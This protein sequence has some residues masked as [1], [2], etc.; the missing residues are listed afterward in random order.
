MKRD[1]CQIKK[2]LATG[3]V[4]ALLATQCFAYQPEKNYWD[5]RRANRSSGRTP[6]SGQNR[7]VRAEPSRFDSAWADRFPPLQ[8]FKPSLSPFLEKTVPSKFL[9]DHRPLLSALSPAYGTIRKIT[10]AGTGPTRPVVVHIQD[11]HHNAEAQG[12]IRAAV[13]DLLASGHVAVVALE[14]ATEPIDL[15]AFVDF[16]HRLPVKQA[17]DW[18]LKENKISGP[19]HAALTHHGKLPRI[20]GVDDPEHYAANVRAVRD[21]VQQAQAVR[22]AIETARQKVEHAKPAVYSPGLAALDKT[23]NDFRAE[24]TALGSYV[25]TLRSTTGKDSS[26]PAVDLFLSALKIE[27]VLDFQQV[28]REREQLIVKLTQ[29]LTKTEIETLLVETAAY[30]GGARLFGAFYHD[31]IALCHQKGVALS[32]FPAMMEYIRYALLADA[33]QSDHL[34]AEIGLLEK[35][36]YNAVVR[37]PQE[38]ELVDRSRRLWLASRLVNFAL[39]PE[40]WD[41]WSAQGNRENVDLASFESFY[42]EAQARDTAMANN[43]LN[44]LSSDGA[45]VLVTGGFHAEGVARLLEQR[46]VSVISFVPKLTKVDLA[47]G[48]AYLSVF[49]QEKTP[50]EKLFQGEKLFLSTKPIAQ[51]VRRIQLPVVVTLLGL[52][53]VAQ[54]DPQLTYALLGGLGQI[55]DVVAGAG[56]AQALVVVGAGALMVRVFNKRGEVQVDSSPERPGFLTT[57]KIKFW[58][59]VREQVFY[60]FPVVVLVPSLLTLLVTTTF[61]GGVGMALTTFLVVGGV[62][63]FGVVVILLGLEH[64]RYTQE[65]QVLLVVPALKIGILTLAGFLV[66]MV[67]LSP[68]AMG[69]VSSMDQFF[70]WI[71]AGE[72]KAFFL[73]TLA[74][75]LLGVW[76]HFVHN[77]KTFG[78]FLKWLGDPNFNGLLPLSGNSS[79]GK[80]NPAPA[81]SKVRLT[82]PA[83]ADVGQI[84]DSWYN[85]MMA[86]LR[87]RSVTD[88][89]IKNVVSDLRLLNPKFCS[90]NMSLLDDIPRLKAH[91]SLVK[92]IVNAAVFNPLGY[93]SLGFDGKRGVALDPQSWKGFSYL[94]EEI[95]M[96]K[97]G[98]ESLH[99][100]L[101][102]D[103]G[104]GVLSIVDVNKIG[105]AILAP[106]ARKK[107]ADLNPAEKASV[108]EWARNVGDAVN[109]QNEEIVKQLLKD[110]AFARRVSGNGRYNPSPLTSQISSSIVKD[111]PRGP[112]REFDAGAPLFVNARLSG[113]IGA[114]KFLITINQP[115]LGIVFLKSEIRKQLAAAGQNNSSP[116][117]ALREVTKGII[118]QYQPVQL[119]E[120]EKKDR[121]AIQTAISLLETIQARLFLTYDERFLAV[122]GR[123]PKYHEF[124]NKEIR[125]PSLSLSLIPRHLEIKSDNETSPGPIQAATPNEGVLGPAEALATE[126]PEEEA[127]PNKGDRTGI[128]QME[129]AFRFAPQ[130]DS[131]DGLELAIRSMRYF[132]D[133]EEAV[134]EVEIQSLQEQLWGKIKEAQ[135]PVA[136]LLSCAEALNLGPNETAFIRAYGDIQKKGQMPSYEEITDASTL[137]EE[138]VLQAHD[139]LVKKLGDL[140]LLPVVYEEGEILEDEGNVGG[141]Y[142]IW[143]EFQL[144]IHK[145]HGQKL[146]TDNSAQKAIANVFSILSQRAR[147]A[148]TH[149]ERLAIKKSRG[150]L[151]PKGVH[152]FRTYGQDVF[153]KVVGKTVVILWVGPTDQS[154]GTSSFKANKPVTELIGN[155]AD[156]LHRQSADYVFLNKNL[157]QLDTPVLFSV[158]EERAGNGKATSLWLLNGAELLGGWIGGPEWARLWGQFYAT[159]APAIE[160]TIGVLGVLVNFA[161]YPIVGGNGTLVFGV[162]SGALFFLSHFVPPFLKPT[163]QV[164]VSKL[165]AFSMAVI[166]GTLVALT[167]GLFLDVGQGP[168]FQRFLEAAGLV[169]GWFFALRLHVWFDAGRRGAHMDWWPI[170]AVLWGVGFALLF[171]FDVLPKESFLGVFP[172]LGTFRVGERKTEEDGAFGRNGQIGRNLSF[173]RYTKGVKRV[174]YL[175][176]GFDLNNVLTTFLG[177]TDIVMVGRGYKKFSAEDV[178]KAM[179]SSTPR[180]MK[181]QLYVDEYKKMVQESGFV[182]SVV[183]EEGPQPYLI[184]IE[185]TELG[186]D[187]ETVV[188]DESGE[189]LS[190]I[191]PSLYG[192]PAKQVHVE[193][194]NNTFRNGQPIVLNVGANTFDGIYAKAIHD[195]AIFLPNIFKALAGR[196]SPESKLVMNTKSGSLVPTVPGFRLESLHSAGDLGQEYGNFFT[197][198]ALSEENPGGKSIFQELPEIRQIPSPQESVGSIEEELARYE[199]LVGEDRFV[200]SHKRASPQFF[201]IWGLPEQFLENLKVESLRR[202]GKEIEIPVGPYGTLEFFSCREN[203]RIVSIEADLR[204]G[205]PHPAGEAPYNA[206]SVLMAVLLKKIAGPHIPIRGALSM[207]NATAFYNLVLRA[208]QQNKPITF[209]LLRRVPAF[210]IPEC[211]FTIEVTDMGVV[212]YT[213]EWTGQPGAPS[214]IARDDQ[215]QLNNGYLDTF[216]HSFERSSFLKDFGASL[217][218]RGLRGVGGPN[219][220]LYLFSGRAG[221]GLFGAA[222]EGV[223]LAWSALLFDPVL[224]LSVVLP[225]FSLIHVW[226]QARQN[227]DLG[228]GKM[229]GMFLWHWVLAVPYG[230]IGT[231]A[232][233]QLAGGERAA[234]VLAIGWHLLSDAYFMARDLISAR[235][236]AQN[237]ATELLPQALPLGVEGLGGPHWAAQV[238]PHLAR[239]GFARAYERAL[240]VL[241]AKN[242]KGFIPRSPNLLVP[243]LESR[244]SGVPVNEREETVYVQ[245]VGSEDV[246]AVMRS[247][248]IVRNWANNG[249]NTPRLVLA[250]KDGA[251][252][253]KL[254]SA[255]KPGV[256]DVLEKPVTDRDGTLN[257]T[258]LLDSLNR[259]RIPSS[260]RLLLMVSPSISVNANAVNQLAGDGLAQRLRE[261]LINLLKGVPVR[262]LEL[263]TLLEV[264]SKVLESA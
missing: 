48:N 144:V 141:E 101:R 207:T 58:D 157:E 218:A 140:N 231:T 136:A 130:T 165:K 248:E 187:P 194:R 135:T 83:G 253:A 255:A 186:V 180:L 120:L 247:A 69:L 119:L 123:Q 205:I 53:L 57:F 46:G 25:E 35:S 38:R 87:Q 31:L 198:Y 17:A 107:E 16:P 203:D 156:L 86:L 85:R 250:A 214:R 208:R 18:F 111:D 51:E 4:S 21:S 174:L 30:R 243:W 236:A 49:S 131:I 154:H 195:M 45:T 99:S 54:M 155:R 125:T 264:A 244:V 104:F 62:G 160:W 220:T 94:G 71:P 134:V 70:S 39:T 147:Q 76:K 115:Y 228:Q 95:W 167:P 138:Q 2:G 219:S 260:A 252:L 10:P 201:E 232:F 212:R 73:S 257:P 63:V 176:A 159:H 102:A 191:L 22:R 129:G 56:V 226:I 171:A 1:N 229:A 189:G 80:P 150:E 152:Q 33:I 72:E 133:K 7:L 179:L 146:P 164:K 170:I 59:P 249:L 19:I 8:V 52:L 13:A 145:E 68:S 158:Q 29:T 118:L 74:G 91:P 65:Q 235:K 202:D 234:Q 240:A 256:V 24:R 27:R 161:L 84:L 246:E 93:H 192:E 168:V 225:L 6:L 196:L 206:G 117:V 67:L 92:L 15:Q 108:R 153:A 44:G 258:L 193:F 162:V 211:E 200:V 224:M 139:S 79:K 88:A 245:V 34:L 78:N 12:N 122:Y 213:I 82:L 3:L 42:R 263:R 36:A 151:Y 204:N 112:W 251:V 227:P 106:L 116:I 28:D 97:P 210:R 241:L 100:Q 90:E 177:A 132:L 124:E 169:V 109:V 47:Q 166:Y 183:V 127:P 121:E 233:Q 81:L 216:L 77:K 66:S 98:T 173:A 163:T 259:V 55:K 238:R 114:L 197:A 105:N 221:L 37:S 143:N 181:D 182:A 103:Y 185:L 60:F 178:R 110:Y 237:T 9:Q 239:P 137:S 96:A 217:S 148:E 230:L 254:R 261:A 209:E 11:V 222:G 64:K 199:V 149:G 26:F 14:G 20:I 61:G 128:L 190:F 32:P 126:K 5:Q 142:D 223:L 172:V 41:E 50:L 242:G 215:F 262:P 75:N 188:D 184:A 43:L 175:G 23:V 113:L 89:E 40:E